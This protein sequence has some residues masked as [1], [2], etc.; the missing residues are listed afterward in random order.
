MLGMILRRVIVPVLAV[1]FSACG[2][3]APP[4]LSGAGDAT[5][6]MQKRVLAALTGETEITPGL[7]LANRFDIANK[8]AARDYLAATLKDL[9]LT[10]QRQAYGTDSENIYAELKCGTPGADAIVLGAHYDTVRVAPG[11]NDD[12]TGVVAVLGVA[13]A[14]TRTTRAKP[15]LHDM[16]FVFF[17]EEERGLVGARNFAEMLKSTNRAVHSVHTIDQVGWDSNHNRAIELELPF[18]GIVDIYKQA[19]ARLKM[20]III[21]VT[22][23]TGSDHNAFRR[24][25]FKA[26]GITEEYRHNDTTRYY[27]KATD[28]YST[29]DFD[30]LASTTRLV[31]ETMRGLT[32]KVR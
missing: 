15:R 17:D 3:Q 26:V 21:H 24:L 11:A 9:G 12:G 7:K 18:D 6:A 14:M 20:D 29:V 2:P 23:E 10:P 28:T 32:Q 8:R 4:A 31:A 1:V 22:T 25:G 16:I 27:H 30:Y 5:T 13:R 19:A